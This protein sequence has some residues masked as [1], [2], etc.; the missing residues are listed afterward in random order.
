MRYIFLSPHLDDIALS[1]GGI[2]H[3]LATLD[4]PVEIWTFFSGSP[5]DLSLSNFAKSLHSRWDL[6]IDAPDIRRSEDIAA[7]KILSAQARHF[8]FLDCIYRVDS[9]RNF[10]VEK[11]EDLY[12][13][14]PS[15]QTYLVSEIR[16]V[17]Q[18]QVKPEDRII[19]PMAIGDHLDHRILL[20]AVQELKRENVL[21]YQ[22][23]PYVIK[24][25][26]QAIFF[27]N[28]SPIKFNL[29]PVDIKKWHQSIAEYRSQLSTFWKD[30][31]W[32]KSE[33]VKFASQ[34]GGQSLWISD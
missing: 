8:N 29:S 22:D 21:F 1:C 2:V 23:Y 9:N 13:P 15:T 7:C 27:K 19:S 20:K 12:Q 31:E 28:Y 24:T 33:I 18:N 16:E 17:I 26:K 11:E 4:N 10:I 30:S 6:P 5:K 3:H 34:G 14:I 25:Q 32:M